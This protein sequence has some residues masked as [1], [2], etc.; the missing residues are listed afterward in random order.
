MYKINTYTHVFI[1]VCPSFVLKSK[2]RINKAGELLVT[3]EVSRNQRRN[4][5][6]CV[7]KLSALIAEASVRPPEPLPEDLELRALRW[8]GVGRGINI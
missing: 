8:V 6:D 4:L 1:L 7:Q 3:S 2:N 5:Q